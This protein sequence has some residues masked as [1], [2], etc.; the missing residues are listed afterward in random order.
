M[1][2]SG[3]SSEV[4][5]S[6][7]QVS[8]PV[9]V[10]GAHLDGLALNWQLRERGASL[11]E[12]TQTAEAYRMYVIPGA[13]ERPGLIRDEESGVGIDIEIWDVPTSEFGSFVS[14]IGQPLGMGKVETVDGTWLAGFICEGYAVVGA[15]EVSGFGGWR[16]YLK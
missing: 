7:Y 6:T 8:I 10:C 9:I 13:I 15:E 14:G 2:E 11:L 5:T 3:V 16:G 4:S 1:P 12:T